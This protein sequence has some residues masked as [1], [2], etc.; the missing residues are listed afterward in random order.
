MI[1]IFVDC[2]LP[3]DC[4]YPAKREARET[5]NTR[6]CMSICGKAKAGWMVCMRMCG[7]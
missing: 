7:N 6:F 5:M 2:E 3:V 4:T 1:G